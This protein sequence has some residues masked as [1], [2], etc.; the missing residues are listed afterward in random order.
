MI[1]IILVGPGRMGQNYL[2]CLQKDKRVQVNGVIGNSE[3]KLKQINRTHRIPTFTFSELPNA[4]KSLNPDGSTFVI[5]TPEWTHYEYLQ[6]A[7]DFKRPII[8]EKPLVGSFNEFINLYPK[9]KR[10]TKP[11]LSCFTSRFD[12]RYTE[13]KKQIFHNGLEKYCIFSRRNTDYLTA[14]RV[15]KKINWPYWITC[16]DVDLCRWISESEVVSAYAMLVG[17]S[18]DS[19]ARGGLHIHLKLENGSSAIIESFWAPPPSEG[20]TLDSDFRIISDLGT[21]ELNL[22]PQITFSGRHSTSNTDIFDFQEQAGRYIGNTPNMFNHFIDVLSGESKAEISKSDAIQ[23][24]RVCRAIELSIEKNEIVQLET[25]APMKFDVV[26]VYLSEA[27][28]SSFPSLASYNDKLFIVFR[29]AGERSAKNAKEDI[30]THHDTDSE[31]VICSS[32]N[33]GISWSKPV[34]IYRSKF[35]VTDPAI[36]FLRDGTCLVRFNLID[37]KL[38]NQRDKLK[39]CFLNHRSDLCEVSSVA[40]TQTS[41]QC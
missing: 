11:L 3:E 40:G 39:G 10:H 8:M 25:I 17:N 34:V 4:L 35:G 28:Y 16:H 24:M 20:R 22:V 12:P 41:P 38:S 15:H 36:T 9:I 19:F 30:I 27:H 31:V 37:T 2:D 5:A 18:E 1:E 23:S 14:S 13:L 7:L 21:F 32:D 6:L 33:G 26:T 29:R